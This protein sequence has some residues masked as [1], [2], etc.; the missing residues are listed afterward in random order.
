MMIVNY[1]SSIVNKLQALLTDDTRVVIYDRHVFIV[2]ATAANFCFSVDNLIEMHGRITGL[3]LS[4][5]HRFLHINVQPWPA[6]YVI[7]AASQPP[8]MAASTNCHI[9][10]LSKMSFVGRRVHRQTCFV[11]AGDPSCLD[12]RRFSVTKH[13]IGLFSIEVH[14]LVYYS[15][16]HN[17]IQH[18]DT[19]NN[20][21]RHSNAQHNNTQH[22]TRNWDFEYLLSVV[23]LIVAMLIVSM[24]SVIY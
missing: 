16:Q 22:N 2:Q 23:I 5:C 18:K 20:D 15:T 11:P 10:D 17:S 1:A 14:L 21:D 4:P 13:W 9:L 8:P 24:L 6:N 19:H 12:F 3:A 7:V